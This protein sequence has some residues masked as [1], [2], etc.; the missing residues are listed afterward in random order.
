MAVILIESANAADLTPQMLEPLRAELSGAEPNTKVEFAASPQ[1]GYG[2]T[3]WEVLYIWLK[4]PLVV[5]AAGAVAGKILEKVV[6]AAIDWVKESHTSKGS[7]A[8]PRIVS[9]LDKDGKVLRAFEVKD[10]TELYDCTIRE[11]EKPPRK[12]PSKDA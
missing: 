3:W 12:L 5:G 6:E 11:R 2:V 8:R 10:G 7:K 4:E 1:R 9:I